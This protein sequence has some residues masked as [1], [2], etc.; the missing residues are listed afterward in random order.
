MKKLVVTSGKGGV[1]KSTLLRA[2]IAFAEQK[3]IRFKAFDGD[4]SNSSLNRFH[5]NAIVVDVDGEL[6]VQNWFE[7]VVIP[8][9]MDQETQLVML[10]LGSGA[11]RIFRKWC[12]ENDAAALLAE[13]K[14]RIVICHVFDPTLDSATPFLD[15]VA[16]L[17][18]VSH[19]IWFNHGMAK[20][21][22]SPHPEKAFEALIR[23]PEFQ[24]TALD[25]E[26]YVIP[27]LL[28]SGKLDA[29]DLNFTNAISPTSQLT[30]FERMRV[31]RWLDQMA[32]QLAEIA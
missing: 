26:R 15:T 14:I 16:A 31:K 32:S 12:D 18:Q 13:E 29:A 20:G 17:P 9:L 25:M 19:T 28:E 11:E 2:A 3:G 7:T 23:E 8:A 27:P 1:G 21:L 24:E 30:L 22:D 5:S 6:L 4:G 10:D